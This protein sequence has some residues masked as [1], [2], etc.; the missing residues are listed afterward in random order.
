MSERPFEGGER[1]LEW[2]LARNVVNVGVPPRAGIGG[3][4]GAVHDAV[5]AHQEH[6][7]RPFQLEIVL[8]GD[9]PERLDALVRDGGDEALI[10]AVL[11][12]SVGAG[13]A[14][15]IR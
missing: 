10:E 1:E 6:A 12:H 11:Q 5:R 4:F 13:E 14:F 15:L 2:P 7:L 8:D 3:G 9:L